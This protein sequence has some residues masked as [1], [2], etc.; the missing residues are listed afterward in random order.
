MSITGSIPV[1]VRLQ[2][3]SHPFPLPAKPHVVC[4]VCR[5]SW[6]VLRPVC[7]SVILLAT[8][9]KCGI[10]V[11]AAAQA[12]T[13]KASAPAASSIDDF[14]AEASS[15][16]AIPAAWIRAV[17]RIESGGNAAAVSPKGAVGLMQI[18]PE[19][20]ADLAQRYRLGSDPTSPHDN[21]IGGTA[22]LR[23]LYD[24]FGPTGFLAA[25]NAGPARYQRYLADGIPLADETRRYLGQLATALPDLPR[26]PLL[27]ARSQSM[28]WRSADL[29]AVQPIPLAPVDL[30][31]SAT[32][33]SRTPS[34]PQPGLVSRM[35]PQPGGLFA[36][37]SK[38]SEH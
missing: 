27:T 21:I 32:P 18:M 25:Y 38:G 30:V 22:Y 6:Q 35:T 11:P 3:R 24:R 23:E 37:V 36:P 16:F 1:S 14:I 12:P 2:Y 31:A 5:H 13:V 15:R 17:I 10:T 34:D 19:T 28:D 8:L 29:F 33:S 4:A 7:L 26:D 9:A 20:W